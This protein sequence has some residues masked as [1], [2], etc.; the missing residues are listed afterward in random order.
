MIDIELLFTHYITKISEGNTNI[1]SHDA[2]LVCK[3]DFDLEKRVKENLSDIL[4]L[5]VDT[6]FP[7]AEFMLAL[8]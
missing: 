8:L 6:M 4:S 7:D 1:L 5:T 2:L 3:F